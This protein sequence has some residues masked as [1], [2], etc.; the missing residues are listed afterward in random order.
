MN[1]R[2]KERKRLSYMEYENFENGKSK[3]KYKILFLLFG[4]WIYLE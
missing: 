4:I 1:I 2:F 3:L